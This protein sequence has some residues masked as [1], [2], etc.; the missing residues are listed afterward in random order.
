MPDS[1]FVSYDH[2]TCTDVHKVRRNPIVAREALQQQTQPCYRGLGLVARCWFTL[3]L[4][5]DT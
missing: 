3:S 2:P 1:L 5:V 4:V